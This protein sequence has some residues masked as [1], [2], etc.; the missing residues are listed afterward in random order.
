ML[1]FYFFELRFLSGSSQSDS[2][3]GSLRELRETIE[4][5]GLSRPFTRGNEMKRFENWTELL[6]FLEG[7][8]VV[9][10]V[11]VVISFNGKTYNGEAEISCSDSLYAISI[12]KGLFLFLEG[13]QRAGRITDSSS[14]NGEI[15]V[16]AIMIE[17]QGIYQSILLIPIRGCQISDGKIEFA[18]ACF[19]E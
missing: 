14:W 4:A 6:N 16:D 8:S 10:T 1:L 15:T 11:D 7:S 12:T 9:A 5:N 3:D 2:F 18:R 19:Q 17:V 13:G